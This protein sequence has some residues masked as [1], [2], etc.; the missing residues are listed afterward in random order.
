MPSIMIEEPE[1][2][3]RHAWRRPS[4]VPSIGMGVIHQTESILYSGVRPVVLE[5][6]LR[7]D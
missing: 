1:G 7:N 5:H 6:I 4:N 3:A 2:V